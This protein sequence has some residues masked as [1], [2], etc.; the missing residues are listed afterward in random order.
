MRIFLRR[1]AARMLRSP[2]GVHC[3]HAGPA[4]VTLTWT[5]EIT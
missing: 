5:T 4:S 1:M 2:D 3:P